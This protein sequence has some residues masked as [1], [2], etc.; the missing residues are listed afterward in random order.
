MRLVLHAVH[1]AGFSIAIELEPN[2]HEKVEMIVER[3]VRQGYRSPVSSWPTGPDGAPLCFKHGGVI[4]SKRSK[5]G[6]EWWSHR[7]VTPS[8]EELYCR[9]VLSGR[10]DDGYHC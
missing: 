5:Q 4:M 6:D 7:V 9:G 8:G 2:E 1:P 10:A 3:I